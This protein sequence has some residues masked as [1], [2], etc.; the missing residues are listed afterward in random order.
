VPRNEARTARGKGLE[1]RAW[2]I[3][4]DGG[5]DGLALGERAIPDP[6]HG[7]VV[8]K[9]N[10][11][12]IN[13]RDLTTIEDPVSRGLPFPTVPNSD[14]AGEVAAVGAGVEAFK[15][16]DRVTS[17]FFEDWVDG[18]I[19]EAAMNSALGGARQGVLAEYVVL[20]QSGVIRAPG[21]LSDEQAATLPCAA[22]T[23]WHALTRPAPVLPG[24]TVLLLGTGGVSVFA[25]QFCTLFGAE[26]IATSSDNAKLERMSALGAAHTINYRET[27][28]WDQAVKDLTGGRGVDRVVE[29]GGPGTLERSISA[30]RVGGRIQLIGTLTGPANRIVPTLLMRKS[31]SLRGIYVGSRAM[32]AEMNRAIEA[33]R[34]EPV[35][36]EIFPF[37]QASSAYHRMRKATHFGKMVI[38][39]KS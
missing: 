39:L 27:P 34:L 6:G 28:E 29:V 8:I 4:S 23:A 15:V 20:D 12:S 21:H 7:Q 22:L 31:I 2:Q 17:C 19:S 5:V 14:A 38:S 9:V 16:G 33:H 30:V 24:E 35:V 3:V 37:E 26:T 25:Q 11:S 18:E 13:Y 1:M 36:S 10:A 32:F